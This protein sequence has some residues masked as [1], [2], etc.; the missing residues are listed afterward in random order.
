M[1]LLHQNT[2]IDRGLTYGVRVNT[3][4]MAISCEPAAEIVSSHPSQGVC[5]MAICAG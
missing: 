3:E 4:A 2:K 1:D 5:L